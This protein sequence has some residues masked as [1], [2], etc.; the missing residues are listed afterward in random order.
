MRTALLR[1]VS[2][3]LSTPLTAITV[4]VASLERQLEGHSTARTVGLLSEEVARR[5]A[6][7]S[8]P[9]RWRDWKPGAS[10]A[11]KPFRRR[12]SP[13]ERPRVS[14]PPL[15]P[16][17]RGARR[18]FLSRTCSPNSSL[19]LDPGRDLVENARRYSPQGAPIKLVAELERHRSRDGAG[20]GIPARPPAGRRL[21]RLG[22][23]PDR[24]G[25]GLEI[26]RRFASTAEVVSLAARTGGGTCAWL[27]LPIAAS[28]RRSICPGRSSLVA[29]DDPSQSRESSAA[30]WAPAT[31]HVSASR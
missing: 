19:R 21:G 6:A 25:L 30:S 13:R 5:C 3:D 12:T 22:N 27:D 10:P 9:K 16:G 4:Q 26:A 28:G 14:A 2:H 20:C 7:G 1:A 17:V 29:E 11:T 31:R 8:R 23:Q 24:R 18:A 15:R